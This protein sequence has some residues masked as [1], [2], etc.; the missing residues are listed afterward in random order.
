MDSVLRDIAA[1]GRGTEA[2]CARTVSLW[3]GVAHALVPII[4]Q[5]GMSALYE[6]ALHL[7]S[8]QHKWL[9]QARGAD[10]DDGLPG[11]SLLAAAASNQRQDDAIAAIAILF[12]TFDRLLVTLIG[13]SLTERLLQPVWD[14]PSASPTRQDTAP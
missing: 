5:R 8:A 7:A 4:G 10:A 11:F 2:I 3:T 13:A 6:R 9:E 1:E 14:V 12:E